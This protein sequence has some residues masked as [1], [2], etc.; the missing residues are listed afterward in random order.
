MPMQLFDKL[1]EVVASVLP[2][3]II[4]LLLH[5]TITPLPNGIL[6]QFI[7]GTFLLILGMGIFMVG[8]DIGMLPMGEMMG[9]ELIKTQ[10]IWLIALFGFL[11]GSMVTIAEPDLQVLAS[12]VSNVNPDVIKPLLVAAVSIGVGIFVVLGMLRIIFGISISK[13]LVIS[14]IIL[15]ILAAFTS[16]NFLPIAFDSG[17]VT[18]GPLSTPFILALGVGVAAVKGGKNSAEDSFGLLA[19]AST[20]P[21]FTVVILGLLFRNSSSSGTFTTETLSQ[22]NNLK[23]LLL[24][25]IK[26]VPIHIKEVILALLPM[27]IIFII[28]KIFYLKMSKKQ[29][30]KIIIGIIYTFVGLVIFL[31][32]VNVGFLPAGTYLGGQIASLHYNWVLIP[33]GAIIGFCLVAA[34]PAVHVL[35]SEVEDV[36]GG[37]ISK[38]SMLITLS[39]GVSISVGLAMIRILTGLNIWWFLAPGYIIALILSFFTPNMFTAIAFDSGGV[40]SG[41]MTAAFISPFTI[42][43]CQVLGGNILT[44]AFGVVAM[45]AMTPLIGI[46]LLGLIY[47]I[48]TKQAESL[49]NEE[50]EQLLREED[51]ESF[52]AID[53]E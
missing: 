7:I 35:N 45:V 15:L 18:T 25:F 36:S 20:G 28:F 13:L 21:I 12:Q 1:K 38:R 32:G 24:S 50:I 40:A 6:G 5:F 30:F 47:K 22:V 33:I 37:Y 49:E 4:V 14:Y 29:L 9:S 19:L 23:E 43:A 42:G 31:T 17:G 44:N 27:I 26:S 2:I 11:I 10:K 34:E 48:K 8:A 53:I 52:L 51:S 41:T 3:P 39:I 46:Q 16:K